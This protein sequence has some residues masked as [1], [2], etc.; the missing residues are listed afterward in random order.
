MDDS[1]HDAVKRFCRVLKLLAE[2]LLEVIVCF[3]VI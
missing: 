1:I 2:N 3:L